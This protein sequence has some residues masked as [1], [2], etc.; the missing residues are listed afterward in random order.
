MRLTETWTRGSGK[1][2]ALY[3]ADGTEIAVFGGPQGDGPEHVQRA[4]LASA[5]PEL[6]E[7]TAR[8]LRWALWITN[9]TAIGQATSLNEDIECACHALAKA[10]RPV[11]VKETA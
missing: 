5:A 4:Q 6:V 11:H 3:L 2:A 7:A 8:L 1:S 9:G 10:R